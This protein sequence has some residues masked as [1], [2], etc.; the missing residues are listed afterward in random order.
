MNKR[1]RI[2]AFAAGGV[3]LVFLGDKAYG[4][5]WSDP[6]E[7]V[8][9]EIRDADL[10]LAR[11]KAV[12]SREAGVQED[13]K[14]IRGLMAKRPANVGNHLVGHLESMFDR[15]GVKA[16]I[17]SNSLPQQQGDFR[18]Y[19]FETRF[20]LAWKPFIDL[21]A[22]LHNSREFLKLLRLNVVSQYEREDRLD[23]DLKVS[24]IEYAPLP[25]K[26]GAK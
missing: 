26:P 19:V 25:P 22:E 5:L 17:S 11:A 13:W 14:K 2:L 21:L 15:V 12:V 24:T 20:K 9:K 3:L 23:V 8:N 16:D 10:E 4:S 7:K 18:E 1:T 6:W